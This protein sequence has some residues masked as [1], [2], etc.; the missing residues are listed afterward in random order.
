[1]PLTILLAWIGDFGPACSTSFGT[2]VMT[3]GAVAVNVEEKPHQHPDFQ[4]CMHSHGPNYGGNHQAI[5]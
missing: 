1:M 5:N 2:G 4:V 3:E